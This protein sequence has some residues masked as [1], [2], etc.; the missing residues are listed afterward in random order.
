MREHTAMGSSYER[1]GPSSSSPSSGDEASSP[2]AFLACLR[3]SRPQAMGRQNVMPMNIMAVHAQGFLK[4]LS[5]PSRPGA[6]TS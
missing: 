4:A 5:S 6:S 1:T 2:A 3:L